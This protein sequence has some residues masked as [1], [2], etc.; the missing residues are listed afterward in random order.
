MLF[1]RRSRHKKYI[2]TMERELE[3]LEGGDLAGLRFVYG[4]FATQDTNLIRRAG[5]AVRQQMLSMTDLQMLK[6]CQRFGTFTSL[7]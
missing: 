2:E 1:S 6:L 7:E 3:R 5:E 4:A